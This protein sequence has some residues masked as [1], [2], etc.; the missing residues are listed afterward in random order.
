MGILQDR[1]KLELDYERICILFANIKYS[2]YGTAIAVIYLYIMAS[3]YSSPDIANIW[4]SLMIITHFPR[5]ILSALFTHKLKN[6]VLT[7][8]NIKPWE[9]YVILSTIL[10]YICFVSVIF[11]PYGENEFISTTLCAIIFMTMATGGAIALTTSLGPILL[12]INLAM[13]A[14]IAKCFWL[15]DQLFIYLG[16]LLFIGYLIITNLIIKQ[17]KTLVETI[18]LKIENKQFALLDPLTKL[19]NRR[20]LDLHVEKLVPASRRSGE[21]FSLLILD[22]DHFKEY[23]DVNGH[24]AG[25]KL[26]IEIA[27]ILHDC[28]RD[29]DLVV[30]YGGEEF[31]VLLPQTGIKDAEV[32]TRRICATVKEKT[33]VTISA[34]LAEFNEKTDF[35]QLIQKA[36]KALYTAKENGRDKYILA[37]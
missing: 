27:N 36:D 8:E 32:I 2:H 16:I 3:K 7:P 13:F 35:N 34:G 24:S 19:W 5:L 23:N 28:S 11:L 22:I 10:P 12:Y 21:P 17:Y 6:H 14:I 30:R 20:R 37:T 9:N 31:I 15:Q 29:Q 25:D 33:K 18:S 1:N 4:V 26:L